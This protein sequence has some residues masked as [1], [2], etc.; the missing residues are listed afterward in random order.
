VT[1]KDIQRLDAVTSERLRIRDGSR[2]W[3]T[4]A[5]ITAHTGDLWVLLPLLGLLWLLEKGAWRRFALTQAAFIFVT[6]AAVFLVKYS[7]RR[8]RP[9][10]E[11]G[12]F[13][14]LL[15]PHSFPSGH[16]ARAA[17]VAILA[18]PAVPGWTIPLL[19]IWV[20]GI[21]LSRVALRLH[22]VLDVVAG[23]GLGAA[24]GFAA[25]GLTAL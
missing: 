2:A 7:I 12:S 1:L 8:R 3:R 18:A 19:A 25:L 24:V 23:Y 15:D 21:G 20:F 9:D 10:G 6:A 4:L 22:F 16:A 5:A 13:Y 11:F 17:G 14:R